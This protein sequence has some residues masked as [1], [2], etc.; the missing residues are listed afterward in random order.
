MVLNSRSRDAPYGSLTLPLNLKP[1]IFSYKFKIVH[2][3]FVVPRKRSNELEG[4][5]RCAF[6]A[7]RPQG[8]K[9]YNIQFLIVYKLYNI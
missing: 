1:Y 2:Y 7:K 3:S 9:N 6:G 8:T 4:F 5:Q